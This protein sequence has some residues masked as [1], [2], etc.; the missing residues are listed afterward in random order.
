[1]P[2]CMHAVQH[3]VSPCSRFGTILHCAMFQRNAGASGSRDT[4]QEEFVADVADLFAENL[5]GAQ[6]SALLLGKAEAA[7]VAGINP[8]ITKKT[9]RNHARALKRHKLKTSKWPSYYWF[10]CRVLNRKT[11]LE[12][13]VELPIFLPLEILE[14]LWDLGRPEVLL[15]EEGMDTASKKHM[16]WMRDQL[17]V[18]HLLGFGLHGDGIPC[19][20]D[21]TESVVMISINLP[22][23]TGKNGRMRIPLVILPDHAVSEH[24][25]DDIMEVFAWSMRHGLAGT[26]ATCRHDGSAWRPSDRRR[27]QKKGNLDFSACMNQCRG[28][29]DWMG[30]CFHLPFHNIKEGCCWLCRCKR[31][32]VRLHVFCVEY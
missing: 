21:R 3:C 14:M 32:E 6:R 19:N 31:K 13:T 18:Q 16:Q 10:P 30:K 25:F 17:Q 26:R 1:M 27:A 9:G 15:E 4:P 20:Y 5:V 11:G 29:W 28:D 12:M 23:L 7:G 2:A 22:G 24:T 8:R